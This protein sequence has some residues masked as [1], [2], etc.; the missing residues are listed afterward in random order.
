MHWYN[1]QVNNLLL[2]AD[3]EVQQAAALP[4]SENDG[5]SADS[6]AGSIAFEDWQLSEE[7]WVAIAAATP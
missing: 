1:L 7:E 3:A 5:A 6:A 4:S 2:F